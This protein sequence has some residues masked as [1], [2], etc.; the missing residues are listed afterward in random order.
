MAK[1]I[2]RYFSHDSNA[3][4]DE[5]IL[6]LR[7]RHKAAGYGVYFMLLERLRDEA[8]Y[9]S[10]KDYNTIAFDLREDAALIKSV[11]EDFGLFEFTDDGKR[12]YSESFLRR[13]RIKDE[14]SAKRVAKAKTAAASRWKG[15]PTEVIAEAL[16]TAPPCV[17]QDEAEYLKRFFAQQEPLRVLCKNLG[18]GPD[19]IGVIRKEADTILSAWKLSD[20]RHANYSDWARHLIAT[21]NKR[22]YKVERPADYTF[23]GSLSGQSN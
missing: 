7:M 11:I 5:R 10:A 9:S 4:N 8:D 20:V 13:M 21:L 1:D 3:R 14:I 12:F 16:T 19:D 18:L 6:R 15:Q 17:S 22:S 2:T 23:D